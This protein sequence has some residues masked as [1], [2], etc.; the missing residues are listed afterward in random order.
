MKA[1]TLIQNI[2]TIY[3]PYLEPPVHGKRMNMIKEIHDGFIAIRDHKIIDFG[4]GNGES[5]IDPFTIVHDAKGS[6]CIPGLIDAHSHLVHA[7]SRENEYHE[8]MI[9]SSY[10]DI[11]NAGGGILSTVEKTRKASFDALVKQARKS[12]DTMLSYGVTVLETKS[13]YGLELKTELKQL[14]VAEKLDQ[15]HPILIKKT[16]LGAHAI[17]KE[18]KKDKIGYIDQIVLDLHQIKELKFV[19]AVD[20]FCEEGVFSLEET[21]RILTEAKDLGFNI[22]MHADEMHSMGGAGLGVYLHCQSVDHLM[23]ISDEDILALAYGNTIANLLPGTSFYLKKAYAPA[24]KMIDEGVAVSISGDYN[25]GSCPTENFQFIMQLA[26]RE[27]HMTPAEILTA[28]TINPAFQLGLSETHGSITI[29]KV[30]NLVLLDIPNLDYL[31]YHFGINHTKDVYI[32]GK[33]VLFNRQLVK[34]A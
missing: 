17:P 28:T 29:G 13:G 15:E 21:A 19:D 33:R 30:A 2:K 5:Y 16:Y 31:F 25:P 18:Y 9:G 4:T 23:A 12:L 20:V 34:E 1:S 24:R 27:L 7:G 3:T 26:S 32:D 8:M 10:L 6:I 22:K 14:E 11:L